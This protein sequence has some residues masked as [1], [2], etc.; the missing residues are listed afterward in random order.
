[1]PDHD[2]EKPEQP[3]SDA[4]DSGAPDSDA[5]V[6]GGVGAKGWTDWVH[7]TF[8]AEAR[9]GSRSS[10]RRPASRSAAPQGH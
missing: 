1:M 6:V 3:V 5:Q 8:S 9:L 10:G 7:R 4:L 2:G